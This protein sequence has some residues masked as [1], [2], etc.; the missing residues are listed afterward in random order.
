[1]PHFHTLTGAP[2]E[3][4]VVTAT[5]SSSPPCLFGTMH[6]AHPLPLHSCRSWLSP[7]LRILVVLPPSTRRIGVGTSLILERPSQPGLA[8]VVLDALRISTGRR[9]LHLHAAGSSF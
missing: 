9:V 3:F 4:A 2:I 7:I 6:L 5:A 1:M 8:G